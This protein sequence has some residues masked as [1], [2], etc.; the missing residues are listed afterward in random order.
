[1]PKEQLKM[2]NAEKLAT[3]DKEKN[4]TKKHNTTRPWHCH[5]ETNTNKENNTRALLQTTRGKDNQP[6]Y[7][8]SL[9]IRLIFAWLLAF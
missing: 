1:M 8:H 6:S 4:K 9:E 7:Y 2:D 3:Q 5:M